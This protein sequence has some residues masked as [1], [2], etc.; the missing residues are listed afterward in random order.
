MG[1]VIE[2]DVA[3]AISEMGLRTPDLGF[4]RKQLG[5]EPHDIVQAVAR[6]N[7]SGAGIALTNTEPYERDLARAAGSYWVRDLNPPYRGQHTW[8]VDQWQVYSKGSM[9][10]WANRGGVM[11]SPVKPSRDSYMAYLAPSAYDLEV[12]E[13]PLRPP[14]PEPQYE[15]A[16]RI[17]EPPRSK[18][19]EPPRPKVS[20]DAELT[21]EPLGV[22]MGIAV[23]LSG[24]FGGV[25]AAVSARKLWR[26]AR[27]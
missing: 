12:H 6:L 23:A 19:S 9:G 25:I 14:G 3:T 5:R 2:R 17:S 4:L 21:L 15:N 13:T 7:A 26:Q 1:D 8:G 10:S 16:Q 11:R 20:L 24:L 18:V 22:V 27:A